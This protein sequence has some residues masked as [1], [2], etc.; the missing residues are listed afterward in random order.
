VTFS[1]LLTTILTIII[2]LAIQII[3]KTN[4]WF[5]FES[6]SS[7]Y[8]NVCLDI[9]RFPTPHFRYY[10]LLILIP[11]YLLSRKVY[12]FLQNRK[13]NIDK[14]TKRTIILIVIVVGSMFYYMNWRRTCR[15]AA[16]FSNLPFKMGE[17]NCAEPIAPWTW[18]DSDR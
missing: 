11:I 9:Y 15:A 7:C 8:G 13:V 3:F 10:R 2:T 1:L 5:W 14:I 17:S 16:Y 6:H 18:R 4:I 12:E